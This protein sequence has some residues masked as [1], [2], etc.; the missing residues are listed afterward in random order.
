MKK[1]M[2]WTVGD[3][4]VSISEPGKTWV[5]TSVKEIENDRWI[6][7]DNTK[8]TYSLPGTRS[9]EGRETI[10]QEMGFVGYRNNV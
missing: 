9:L 10:I 2:F 1:V 4:V 5:V 7:I 6:C 8:E 3:T